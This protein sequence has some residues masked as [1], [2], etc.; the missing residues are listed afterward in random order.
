MFATYG[1]GLA[2]VFAVDDLLEL[3]DG[4]LEEIVDISECGVEGGL[5][6]LLVAAL[7]SKTGGECLAGEGPTGE[8]NEGYT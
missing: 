7:G 1:E 6:D 8:F 2:Q 3:D 4:D 5:G